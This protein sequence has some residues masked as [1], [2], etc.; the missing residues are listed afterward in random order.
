MVKINKMGQIRL[1]SSIGL[2][3]FLWYLPMC[4]ACG[5]PGAEMGGGAGT[6]KLLSG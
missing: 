4:F 5:V 6:V 1:V 2:V 3:R